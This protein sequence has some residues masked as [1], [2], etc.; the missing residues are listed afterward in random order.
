MTGFQQRE[1]KQKRLGQSCILYDAQVFP[2]ITPAWFD[3]HYWA[4]Q[5]QLVGGAPGRGTSCFIHTPAGEGVLR[6][7]H[8]GGLVGRWI[9]DRYIW[10]G[11][12]ST[13]AWQ[14]FHLTAQLEQ[15]G[16]PVP[17]PWAA[18]LVRQGLTYRADLLTQR[19]PHALPLAD[20]L[21][22]ASAAP[23]QQ[24]LCLIQVGQLI[25][26]F[27]QRGLNHV[28]LNPRNLLLDPERVHATQL[29]TDG[30]PIYQRANSGLWLIDLDRCQLGCLTPA[31]AKSNL[32]RLLR[33]L[34]KLDAIQ[35]PDWFAQIEAGYRHRLAHKAT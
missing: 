33:G 2:Q 13:R 5:G 32:Q 16:F 34:I 31:Q 24:A 10:T 26:D 35:A 8:R 3:P 22:Q 21:L 11:L 14:E 6:H 23:D 12:H 7:Y 1:F 4:E 20:Y 18:Q 27:H 19:L 29:A 9:Q 17:R 30:Q 15:E 28:D 25:A